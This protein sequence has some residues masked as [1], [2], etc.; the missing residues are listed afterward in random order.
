VGGKG[1]LSLPRA[2]HLKIS[3]LVCQPYL[4]ISLEISLR[5]ISPENT[6]SYQP[7]KI[8]TKEKNFPQKYFF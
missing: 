1:V 4:R 5:T 7:Y 8:E 2:K 6:R 3:N